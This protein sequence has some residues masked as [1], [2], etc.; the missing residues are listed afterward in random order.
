MQV[1]VVGFSPRQREIA[2]LI[3]EAKTKE[4]VQACITLFGTDA[5]I[6]RDMLTAAVLDQHENVDQSVVDFL[7]KM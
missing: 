5:I 2:N 1:E 3:W 7:A 6:A 4:E